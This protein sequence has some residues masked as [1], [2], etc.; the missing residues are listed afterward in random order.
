MAAVA[1]TGLWLSHVF[2]HGAEIHANAGGVTQWKDLLPQF[3]SEWPAGRATVM[4]LPMALTGT[5]SNETAA[6]RVKDTASFFI[7][8]TLPGALERLGDCV[9]RT[10]AHD[11]RRDCGG[12]RG[13]HIGG[14][15]HYG[16][17]G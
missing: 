13:L 9:G 16:S 11:A 5:L 14:A 15:E 12:C 17:T 8:S 4:A 6:K 2:N 3:W 10:H 7:T 1:A